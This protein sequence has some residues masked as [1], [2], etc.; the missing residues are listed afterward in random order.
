MTLLVPNIELP[1]LEGDLRAA[2]AAALGLPSR[3]LGN[4]T[5]LRRNLDAR[6]HRFLKFVYTLAVTVPDDYAPPAGSRFE[7]YRVPAPPVIPPADIAEAAPVIVGCGP[8]GLFA[9]L[10]FAEAGLKPLLVDRGQPVETRAGDVQRYWA[11]GQLQPES[12]MYFGEGGAGTFSDGKLNT[13]TKHAW[14]P[15]ILDEFVAAGAHDSIR[16]D[17]KPHVGTD[18][19]IRMLPRLR[20]RL[21][22][23]GATI[24]FNTRFR[25]LRRTPRGE[26]EV[27]L[28]DDWMRAKPLVLAIGHS[29]L[30]TY[31]LLDQRGVALG[32]K[33]NA[34]GFRIEH[35]A[36]MITGRFYGRDPRVLE[37][38]GNAP[39]QLSAKVDHQDHSVYSFCCCPGGEVVA[40][41]SRPGLVSVNG[42]SFSQRN[43]AFTNAAMVANLEAGEVAATPM[44]SLAWRERI[45]ATC[46]RMGGADYGLP[47][48]RLADFLA[49]RVSRSLPKNSCRRP[50]VPADLAD[51]Y[52][53]F[54]IERLRSGLR[55]LER[56][57][58]GWIDNG[59]LIGAETTTSAPLRI[60][61]TPARES[62]NTPD[63][64]PVG[65]GS[66]YA[67]GI[68]TSA[69][70]GLLAA[71]DWIE[72]Q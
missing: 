22:S 31:R 12:N 56:R 64:L 27:L 9:A 29:A 17:A 16:Y 23:L 38:L 6:Q 58:P 67:G 24:R 3:D 5:I 32:T 25:D 71:K 18:H 2:A 49:G 43:S 20:Q 11:D 42:M 28:N 65:E 36:S 61:R 68:M 19:L 30:D 15:R 48:Q 54:L 26:L 34:V 1:V 45:E 51:L 33:G 52:P 57:V 44:D 39:Y 40:C 72:R 7:P 13:R 55:A 37:L 63:L 47:A 50:L 70:D 69:L 8:A 35:P 14:M 4:V 62:E 10:A 66:G 59:L 41:S 46:F 21:T 60:L 53:P